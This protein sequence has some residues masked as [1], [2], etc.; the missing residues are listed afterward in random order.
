MAE[1]I[2]E[3]HLANQALYW[4]VCGTWEDAA[5]LCSVINADNLQQAWLGGKSSVLSFDKSPWRTVPVPTYDEKNRWHKQLVTA[6][7]QAEKGDV[8]NAMEKI[9]RATAKILPGFVE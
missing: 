4:T 8:E 3:D 5:Y 1:R 7:L 2:P 9:C 6:C